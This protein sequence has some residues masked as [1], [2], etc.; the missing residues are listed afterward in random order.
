M[1]FL[2]KVS[3]WVVAT[4]AN[5]TSAHAH[6]DA[7]RCL[8]LQTLSA[9]RVLAPAAAIA[10]TGSALAFTSSEDHIDA[11]EYPWAHKG[12]FTTFDHARLGARD[13]CNRATGADAS[14]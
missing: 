4:L 11:P 7:A 13:S 5:S 3:F 12:P 9:G 6:R 8:L 14:L 10:I 2:R 1:A